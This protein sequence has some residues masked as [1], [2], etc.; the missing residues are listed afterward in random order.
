MYKNMSQDLVPSQIIFFKNNIFF[1]NAMT[2]SIKG[3]FPLIKD[4]YKV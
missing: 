4:T 3:V 2:Q 1:F